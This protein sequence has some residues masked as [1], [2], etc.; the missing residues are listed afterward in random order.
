M[1]VRYIVK[2]RRIIDKLEKGD[3]A[4]K[5]SNSSRFNSRILISRKEEVSITVEI[6]NIGLHESVHNRLY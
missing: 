5:T 2:R 3:P 1:V 4:S 6:G